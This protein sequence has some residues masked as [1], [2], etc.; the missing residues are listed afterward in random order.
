MS[1]KEVRKRA[2]SWRKLLRRLFLAACVSV[3]L[4]LV[5]FFTGFSWFVSSL[6]PSLEHPP[7]YAEGI[8]VLTGGRER[9]SKSL[10]MLAEGKAKRLLISGVNPQT[11]AQQIAR[12]TSQQIA[13]FDCCV[14]LDRKALNTVGN[15]EE[16]ALWVRNNAFDSL[17]VVTSAYHMPRALLELQHQLPEIELKPAPVF[18]TGLKLQEW[19]K[20]WATTKLLLREFVKYILVRT[21]VELALT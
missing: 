14:D 12:L 18:H 7:E 17:L 6:T 8:V 15:A 3:S 2:F 19:Y 9:I 1:A 16:T 10:N 21:R 5:A 11:T 4:F 20:S 13:L